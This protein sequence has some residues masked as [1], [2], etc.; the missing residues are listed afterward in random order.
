[1]NIFLGIGLKKGEVLLCNH[2]PQ[3]EDAA[4]Q[5][6]RILYEILGDTAIDIQHVGSTS[7]KSI[8]AK[9]VIDLIVGVRA[10]ED[11]KR[12]SNV[13]EA[14]VFFFVGCEGTERQPVYQCGEYDAI[15][16][17]MTFL[18]HYIHIVKFGSQQ[19]L[20]YINVRDYLNSHSDEAKA[21]E[22]VKLESSR[23]NS[24]SLRDYH[25]DKEMFV[26]ALIKRAN[27]WKKKS[28]LER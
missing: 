17:E 16:K 5:T 21:Y 11:I 25:S 10:F 26:T 22:K 7:V 28:D 18:T 15:Q 4:K 13:L 2:D 3:W 1:M 6:I 8:Q 19:W 23:K 20:N 12:F 24:E 27:R 9:P 14:N